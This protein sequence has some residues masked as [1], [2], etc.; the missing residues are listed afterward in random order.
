[1]IKSQLIQND[2]GQPSH[3]PLTMN[4]LKAGL[5]VSSLLRT[6]LLPPKTPSQTPQNAPQQTQ[7]P[8]IEETINTG[9]KSL[10]TKFMKELENIKEVLSRTPKTE[11]EQ[12]EELK[13]KINEVLNEPNETGTT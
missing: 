2:K 3:P 12:I 1:M 13:A 11:N 9:L 7:T 10:E 6:F 8:Q 4:R 5:G